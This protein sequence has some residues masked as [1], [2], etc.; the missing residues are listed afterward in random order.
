M[1]NSERFT[2]LIRIFPIRITLPAV[3]SIVLLSWTI[4]VFLLPTFEETL[5]IR[6]K[7]LVQ[8][9]VNTAHS[10]L[11]EYKER[12][13]SGELSQE[14]AQLRAKMRISSMRYGNESKDYFW[15]NTMEPRMVMHPYRPDLVGENLNSYTDCRG[16]RLFVEA[17]VIVSKQGSGFIDYMWQWKDDPER[18]VQKVSY[19]K[20]FK[21]WGWVIGSGI[22]IEDVH[23][24]ISLITRRLSVILSVIL[25]TIVLLTA[26]IIWQGIKT[27]RRKEI[28]ENS[29]K[30]SEKKYRELV[31]DANSIIL[32]LDRKGAILFI[33]EFA[34]NFFGFKEHEIIGKSVVGTIVPKISSAGQNLKDFIAGLCTAPQKYSINENENIKKNGERVWISWTNK[35]VLDEAGEVEAI[36]C[37]GN[38]ITETRQAQQ[39]LQRN[40]TLLNTTQQLA[41][42][43]GWEIDLENNLSFW[44]DEVYRIH[45]LQPDKFTSTDETITVSLECYDPEDRPAIMDAFRKCSEKGQSYDLEF[46]FT[47]TKGRRKWI[48]TIAN[49]VMEGERIIKVVGY[50]SDITEQKQAEQALKESEERIRTVV[51]QA[52]DAFFLLDDS[53]NFVDVNKH[54][55]ELLGYTRDEMIYMC[56]SDIDPGFTPEQ[57]KTFIS[58]LEQNSYYTLESIYYTKDGKTFPVEI[59]C[60]KTIIQEN[61]RVIALSRDITDRKIMEKALQ[62]SEKKYRGLYNNAQIGMSLTK[63][64]DGKMVECNNKMAS[65][66]GYETREQ[67][68]SEHVTSNQYVDP[69]QHKSLIKELEKNGAINESIVQL[70]RRDKT[71]VWVRMS[72]FLYPDIDCIESVVI[73]ITDQKQVEQALKDREYG[74][75]KLFDNMTSAVAVYESIDQGQNFIF[76]DINNAAQQLDKIQKEALV[77]RQIE[78]VFPSIKDFGIF[79]I[80]RRVYK[81]GKPKYFP[82]KAYKDERLGEVWRESWVY[83]LPGNEIVWLYNDVTDRKMI[84]QETMRSARLASIGEL[85]AG[86]AHEVN[87]P[88]NAIINC[89]ELTND[90]LS[91][92]NLDTKWGEAIIKES[93]R[94]AKIVKSLL[95]YARPMDQKNEIH[96]IKNILDELFLLMQKTFDKNS[97]ILSVEISEH[98]SSVYVQPQKIQEVF[99]NIFTN[100]IYAVNQKFGFEINKKRMEIK[101]ENVESNNR[102]YVRIVFTDNGIGI[103]KKSLKRICDPFYSLKPV[104]EGS[105]LGLNICYNIIKEH[106]GRLLFE[107]NEDQYT[108]VIVELPAAQDQ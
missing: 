8:E 28:A 85:A 16:K 79:D 9:V 83:K 64:S 55:C 44:T 84:Q 30:T 66:F 101:T 13:E 71:R 97:V 54:A 48:R 32:Q 5:I 1:R 78:E 50:F 99:M 67:Y 92:K 100:A 43:G 18:I 40:E 27:E 96:T 98:L 6:K 104:G 105:G 89:A 49:P 72:C 60:C 52:G 65:I 63:T 20:G 59:R 68:I 103:P 4:L 95:S 15:I 90:I 76:K 91:E 58:T 47:T 36:L 3:L 102:A 106:D 94:I 10:L 12:E 77:G 31:Q 88:L 61:E 75:Q 107:S 29:L 51:D 22:Y 14:E 34:Q 87:N 62:K 25:G 7:Q 17:A 21:P 69:E 35:A 56:V 81:T 37:V 41:R 2:L 46:P 53:G 93:Q 57:T 45:D 23:T 26:F 74:F 108:R 38:N 11:K 86:I 19:V 33:N 73:D 24:E 82:E 80:F 42:I 39:Q 70:Y